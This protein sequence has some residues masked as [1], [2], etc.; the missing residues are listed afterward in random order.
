MMEHLVLDILNSM[1]T[2]HLKKRL[3]EMFSELDDDVPD[4]VDI[5]YSSNDS[6]GEEILI[7]R[8]FFTLFLL[9]TFFQRM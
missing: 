9:L 6:D 3:S 2:L 1:Q 7:M 8:K 4:L 5:D